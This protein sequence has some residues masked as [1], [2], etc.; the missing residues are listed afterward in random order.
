M[1]LSIYGVGA[2]LLATLFVWLAIPYLVYCIGME[3]NLLRHSCTDCFYYGKTCAF[4][5]GKPCAL[6]FRQGDPQH[7]GGREISWMTLIPDFLISIIAI[8][9]VIILL[10]IDF[11]W[12]PLAL[13]LLL[14]VLSSSG[15]GVIRGQLA[16]NH[17][18]QREIGCAAER[19]FVGREVS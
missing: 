14:I 15:N 8:A 16:R 7:F 12:V 4:G 13:P 9:S 2:Y 1:S 3:L 11:A 17:C 10:A 18:R 5:K 6:L 19:L